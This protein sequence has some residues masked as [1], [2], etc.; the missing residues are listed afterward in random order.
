MEKE[1]NNT[2]AQI[3]TTTKP[4]VCPEAEFVDD[5]DAYMSKTENNNSVDVVL[6]RFDEQH[7]KYKFMEANLLMKRKKLEVQMPTLKKTLEILQKLKEQKDD[8]ETEYLMSDL[9]FVKAV[10]PPTK[11]V[12]LWL[13]AN[14]MLEY[15][16]ED[17][18]ALV[19]KNIETAKTHME[20]V[21]EDL[22]YLRDQTTVTEVN[23]ARVFNWDIKRRQSGAKK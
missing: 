14:V 6:R 17:A 16:I 11:T 5:V 2:T 20:Q 18:E 13:G 1:S 19:S 7:A 8:F 22:D 4:K 21:A 15:S 12:C 23:M 3:E 9:V 10:V